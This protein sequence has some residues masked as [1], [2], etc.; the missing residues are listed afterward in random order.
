MSPGHD[1]PFHRQ[2]QT[3]VDEAGEKIASGRERLAKLEAHK[4][5]VCPAHIQRT[6]THFTELFTRTG[7]LETIV[8]GINVKTTGM[9]GFIGT[10]VGAVV[11]GIIAIVLAMLVGGN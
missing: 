7:Q 9:W 3:D 10:M 1:C 4:E 8:E 5:S 2:I 6:Q 11:T